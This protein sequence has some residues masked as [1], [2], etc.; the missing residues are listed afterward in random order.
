MHKNLEKYLEEIGHY[1]S[2]PGEREEILNEIRS[3]ILEK[4]ERESGPADEGRLEKIIAAY[5][6]PRRVAEKYLDGR[7]IIAPGLPALLYSA[8]RGCFSRSTSFLIV[9]GAFFKQKL[10]GLSLSLR[11]RPGYRR[12]L[13]VRAHGL[14]DRLRHR[15]P[16]P[17]LTSPGPARRPGCP[18]PSSPSISM[19]QSRSP[20]VARP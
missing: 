11:S 5:G 12:Y 18:G 10:H 4:A 20:G 17:V 13:P 6:K 9:P 15:G 1:L 14:P 7:P 8:I 2:D 3:H 16:C 19:R